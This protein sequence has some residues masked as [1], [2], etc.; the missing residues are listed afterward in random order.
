M[1]SSGIF[2]EIK[3][4]PWVLVLVIA[5]H[6][7][8]AMLLA[9][10]LIN[11]SPES[12]VEKPNK[13][14]N[15]V[16]INT[17]KFDQR[18]KEKQRQKEEKKRIRALKL[19]QAAERK[20]HELEKKK[21]IA[22]KKK[23]IEKEKQLAKKRQLKKMQQ[24]KLQQARKKKAEKQ[25]QVAIEKQKKQ[26]KEAAARQRVEMEKKRRKEEKA[27]FEQALKEE[28]LQQEEARLQAKHAAIMKS[29]RAQY[30]KLIAQKVENNWLRPADSAEG[31][32]CN[33]IVTQSYTGDV[34]G[35]SLQ[36]CKADIAFQRSVERAV[37]KA[38]PLPLPPNPDIFDRKI[39]FTFRPK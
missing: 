29:L 38:S 32:F 12:S 21:Q 20:K 17:K 25:R 26:A 39:Y 8:L 10:N 1:G 9:I 34:V 24:A 6:L 18:V 5:A 11:N 37:Q 28:E 27:E 16:V 19:T 7:G 13:I 3:R 2:W 33:V 4:H 35:V 23:R 36:S 31:Q 15:A 14:I 22:L 30:V